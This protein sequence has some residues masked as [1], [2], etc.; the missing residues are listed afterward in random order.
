MAAANTRPHLV[1]LTPLTDTVKIPLT[2]IG[3]ITLQLQGGGH[4]F[5]EPC[6]SMIACLNGLHPCLQRLKQRRVGSNVVKEAGGPKQN[7]FCDGRQLQHTQ[8]EPTSAT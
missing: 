5:C 3:F 2:G 4:F 1:A 8:T 7:K 6:L